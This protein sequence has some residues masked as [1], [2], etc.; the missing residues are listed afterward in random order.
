MS[1]SHADLKTINYLVD[2]CMSFADM[3]LR[4]ISLNKK[5]SYIC[6]VLYIYR[7]WL[8]DGIRLDFRQ[9]RGSLLFLYNLG[10]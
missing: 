2:K 7:S 3:T 8:N 5:W 4:K 1:F 6:W 9:K 10:S